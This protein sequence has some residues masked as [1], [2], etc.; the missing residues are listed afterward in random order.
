MQIKLKWLDDACTNKFKADPLNP[1]GHISIVA[2]YNS[3]ASL[4]PPSSGMVCYA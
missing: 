4:A 2:R 1:A 3:E